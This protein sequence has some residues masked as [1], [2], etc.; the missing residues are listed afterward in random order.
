MLLMLYYIERT[1]V[2]QTYLCF[3]NVFSIYAKCKDAVEAF[4]KLL[5]S[6]IEEVD[7]AGDNP[8]KLELLRSYERDARDCVSS[9]QSGQAGILLENSHFSRVSTVPLAA[10]SGARNVRLPERFRERQ[11]ESD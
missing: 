9:L 7:G 4:Y 5:S 11:D 6:C 3:S 8:R 1:S 2:F 10:T